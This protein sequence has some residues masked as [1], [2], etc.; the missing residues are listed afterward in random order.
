[1]INSDIELAYTLGFDGVHLNSTQF[2]KI[3]YAKSHNLYVM[4]STHNTEEMELAILKGV[5]AITYSPIFYTP[6]K[7]SPLGVDTLKQAVGRY[8]IDIFALGGIISKKEIDLVAKSGCS[9]F[10][11]I[12]YFV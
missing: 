9:G 5:D 2:D 7:Q 4:I 1:M 11:S 6:N 10:A 12:R 3:E 8:S